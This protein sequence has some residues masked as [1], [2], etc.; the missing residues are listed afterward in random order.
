MVKVGVEPDLLGVFAQQPRA[1]AME[2]A[3]PGQRIGHDAGVRPS[4]WAQMRS[5]RRAISAAARREKVISRMRRGSAPLTIR[6]ATRCASVL[7]LPDPAPAMTRSGPAGAH[8]SPDAVL[9]GPSLFGIELFPHRSAK[10]SFAPSATKAAAKLRRIQV[11]TRGRE[12]TW[13]RIEAANSP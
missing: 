12:I 13:S 11:K 6:C 5:T 8:A 9:D 4:T 3:G 2:R 10:A 7:V 1:D